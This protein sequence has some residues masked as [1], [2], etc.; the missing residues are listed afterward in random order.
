MLVLLDGCGVLYLPALPGV[1]WVLARVARNSLFIPL[2]LDVVLQVWQ[3]AIWDEERK[4]TVSLI[5]HA[6]H[7]YPSHT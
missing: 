2:C 4:G 7:L 3:V 6:L 1:L 5:L